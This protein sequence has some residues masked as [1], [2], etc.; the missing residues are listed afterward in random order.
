[1]KPWNVLTALALAVLALLPARAMAQLQ[2]SEFGNLSQARN[3]F[4]A[5]PI[6]N[7]KALV[8]GGYTSGGVG[9]D[10][11]YMAVNPGASCEIIDVVNH[12]I[13]ATGSLNVPHAEFVALLTPDSNVV[14]ISGVT[15]E[16]Q[17]LTPVVELYDRASGEW[18]VIGSLFVERR[19]HAACFI[20][21][22][23]ILVVGGRRRDLGSLAD[24]EIFNIRTGISRFVHDY[25]AVINTAVAG[26]ASN[27]DILVFA[28]REGGAYSTIVPAIYKYDVAGDRWVDAGRFDRPINA[29]QLLTLQNGS[30]LVTGGA[31][32]NGYPMTLSPKVYL[33]RG[34]SFAALTETA[35]ARVWHAMA[36]A[37]KDRVIVT[38]GWLVDKDAT[39]TCEWI[40]LRGGASSP[41]PS[42]CHARKFF[43]TLAVPVW[44]GEF[45]EMKVI[46]IAGQDQTHASLA[47]VEILGSAC[48][49][50]PE[51]E[52]G[53]P[54]SF[55]QGSTVVLTAPE[56]YSYR[57]STGATSRSI[58]VANSGAYSVTITNERGCSATSETTVVAVT[59][60]PVTPTIW[61]QGTALVASQA[62]TYQ[63]SLDGV[64]IQG[65]IERTY[66]PT[67]GGEYTVTITQGGECSATSIPFVLNDHRSLGV[68]VTGE[69][70]RME[71][72]PNPASD[73]LV[74]ETALAAP[75]VVGLEL[76]NLLGERVG[77]IDAE[78]MS[79]A[80]H[81]EM[82]LGDLPSGVYLLH[83]HIG[84]RTVM[85]KVVR[86]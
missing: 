36:Q 75:A 30:L 46:A 20:N 7:G 76:M 56:G 17:G 57:W 45:V 67:A 23:E 64:A 50:I 84:D 62:I 70:D 37:D 28:G 83:L 14:A 15:D 35:V 81:L 25:P 78:R 40:D 29:P 16:Q 27:G 2:W 26:R 33:E 4:E 41:A 63:W 5:L 69:A 34:G 39:N 54:L 51:V 8:I 82:S 9:H 72:Y 32:V 12:T 22:E 43:R 47:S 77:G 38:G 66:T 19:Q 13:T 53:G 65:A 74:V 31:Y 71:I 52:A 61:A 59:P 86:Q 6:G 68:A 1:M 10:G 18:R 3:Y 11:Y 49:S 42:M 85:R 44:N 73:R 24:A 55:C 58:V 79:G 48:I 80:V 21:D 60:A